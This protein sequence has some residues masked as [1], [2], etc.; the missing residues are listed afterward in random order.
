MENNAFQR[1]LVDEVISNM[2]KED[3]EANY[4]FD[5][6]N[7]NCHCLQSQMKINW[8]LKL[9]CPIFNFSQIVIF[10]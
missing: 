6:I 5:G 2:I 7:Q 9:I 3:K 8:P 10:S 4:I 1:I